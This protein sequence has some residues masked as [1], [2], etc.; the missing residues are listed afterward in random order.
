MGHSSLNVPFFL[1]PKVNLN[2][3][4]SRMVEQPFGLFYA[5]QKEN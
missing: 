4:L 5:E 2:P 3:K 1:Y